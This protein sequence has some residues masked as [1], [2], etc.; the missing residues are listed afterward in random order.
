MLVSL[1][2]SVHSDQ[3]IR[4]TKDNHDEVFSKY[5]IYRVNLKIQY[6]VALPLCQLLSVDLPSSKDNH[7]MCEEDDGRTLLK[8]TQQFGWRIVNVHVFW[9]FSQP[10]L[11][12]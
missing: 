8:H 11:Q 2:V 9:G 4:I 6:S 3:V 5:L 7:S 12:S 1:A 10:Y